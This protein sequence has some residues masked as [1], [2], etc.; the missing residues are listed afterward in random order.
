[1]SEFKEIPASKLS[2]SKRKLVY[3]VGLNDA[4]YA[5]TTK[6]NSITL[7]CPIYVKWLNMLNRCYSGKYP[8]YADCYIAS[9]WLVFSVFKLWMESCDWKE[10]DLDKDL[11]VQGNKMYSSG[12]CLFIDKKINVLFIT[13]VATR[14]CYRLGVSFHKR[15]GK[16]R[17][18]CSDGN[19][20]SVYLG[21]FVSDELA[22]KAYKKYKYNL[23]KELAS[24]QDEPVKSAM[25]NHV[26][27]EY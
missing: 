22:H 1:M 8:T 25:L 11:L 21:D 16:F 26:I 4:D 23:I 5:V 15:E 27:N 17:S 24:K 19:G 9:E 10:K 13:S 3:G 12:T 6:L 2:L 20:G 18:T 14:G 7:R